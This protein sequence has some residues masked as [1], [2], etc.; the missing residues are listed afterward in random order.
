MQMHARRPCSWRTEPLLKIV[1]AHVRMDMRVMCVSV[2][3]T[4]SN[5]AQNPIHTQTNGH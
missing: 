3:S 2:V 5:C 4:H 1:E